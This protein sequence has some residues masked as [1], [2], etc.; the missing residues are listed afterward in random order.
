MLGENRQNS[1]FRSSSSSQDVDPMILH[2]NSSNRTS[3]PTISSTL[4]SLDTSAEDSPIAPVLPVVSTRLGAL[5]LKKLLSTFYTQLTKK[6][7]SE[8][9][10]TRLFLL[11]MFQ[12][13]QI[14]K[15]NFEQYLRLHKHSDTFTTQCDATTQT[16]HTTIRPNPFA[17][18][19]SNRP[20]TELEKKFLTHIGHQMK[21]TLLMM[22][23]K[24]IP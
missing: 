20:R 23:F 16:D 21:T 22:N 12:K 1:F 10:L 13:F 8:P 18:N 9:H 6:K 14:T 19:K 3:S 24:K 17:R 7:K 15:I 2:N 4:T 5:I 11:N